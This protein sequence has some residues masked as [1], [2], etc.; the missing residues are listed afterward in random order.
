MKLLLSLMT[1]AA[2]TLS[3]GARAA[4]DAPA[5]RT[6]SIALPAGEAQTL[7]LEFSVGQV[8]IKAGDTNTI[9]ATVRAVPGNSG[10][11]IFRWVA[12]NE[13]AGQLPS[14]LH[15]THEMKDGTLTLCLSTNH[16]DNPHESGWKSEWE[17][18]LPARLHVKLH[19]NVGKGSVNGVAGGLEMNLNVGKIEAE[20]PC[21]PVKASLN[22]GNIETRVADADY[23]K[24]ELSTNVGHVGFTV[25][26]RS[27]DTGVDHNFVSNSQSLRGSGSTPYAMSVNT[28][29]IDLSLG[30]KRIP[31]NAAC[32]AVVPQT[33]P[34]PQPASHAQ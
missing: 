23:G 29:H 28:G 18:T 15:L 9:K 11:F 27:V 30:D 7:T 4:S 19:G 26:G 33:T 20:L 3:V 32:T 2:L 17:V 22:V 31:S 12:G 1:F 10:Q 6:Y 14:G 21:G 13:K 16:C 8:A 34:A 24:V 5:A 25:D